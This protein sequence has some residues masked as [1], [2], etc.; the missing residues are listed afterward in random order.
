MKYVFYYSIISYAITYIHKFELSVEA[1]NME[2]LF[3]VHLA[4]LCYILTKKWTSI[5]L[6]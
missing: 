1:H 3:R 5:F 6:H 2:G 4:S